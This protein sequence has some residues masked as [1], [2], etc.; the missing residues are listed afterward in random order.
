MSIPC[1]YK[2]LLILRKTN[3][4]FAISLAIKYQ[5]S[6]ALLTCSWKG[7]ISSTAAATRDTTWLICDR[8]PI[9]IH[10]DPTGF[11]REQTSKLNRNTMRAIT[12]LSFR[13]LTVALI[14]SHAQDVKLF[15]IY[16]LDQGGRGESQKLPICI[17]HNIALILLARGPYIMV[18]QN[19]VKPI[20]FLWQKCS[21]SW[22]RPW[23]NTPNVAEPLG[24]GEKMH[25]S[26]KL[27]TGT[28]GKKRPIHHLG[29][30]CCIGCWFCVYII[31]LRTVPKLYR[32][33]F[34]S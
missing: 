17:P 19:L 3:I 15:L 24:C 20:L 13:F 22:V 2:L 28:D 12:L 26:Q 5:V 11:S 33:L 27:V 1:A 7:V 9:A 34:P 31:P 29:S 8:L 10:K 18:L 32:L 16:Y 4:I 21:Q 6:K 23:N 14:S 30:L 25:K